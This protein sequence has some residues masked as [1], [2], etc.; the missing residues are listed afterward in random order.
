MKLKTMKW[1]SVVFLQVA[2]MTGQALAMASRP[3]SDPSAPPPPA[4]VSWVPV[5]FMVGVF[6]FFLIRPQTKQ[7]REH[8]NMLGNIKKGDKV[9]TQ[10]GIIATVVNIG[11]H[12]VDVKINEDTKAQLLK[13]AIT[14]VFHEQHAAAEPSKE[15]AVLSK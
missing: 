6:Y 15:P 14:S 9:V 10:G 4:W 2:L 1:I 12:V 7:R 11:P 3:N 5:L 8:D 13:S